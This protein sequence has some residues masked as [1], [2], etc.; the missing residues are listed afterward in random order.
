VNLSLLFITLLLDLQTNNL[1][2]LTQQI[3]EHWK[4]SVD[5]LLLEKMQY[6]VNMRIKTDGGMVYHTE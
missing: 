4:S 6:T 5:S 1:E 2:F 3:Y